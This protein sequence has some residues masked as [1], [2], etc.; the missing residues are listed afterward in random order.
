MKNDDN[1]QK[2]R[3][4][5]ATSSAEDKKVLAAHRCSPATETTEGGMNDRVDRRRKGRKDAS[6]SLLCTASVSSQGSIILCLSPESSR[7]STFLHRL[8]DYKQ[9]SLITSPV[10][11]SFFL[12]FFSPALVHSKLSPVLLHFQPLLLL[13]LLLLSVS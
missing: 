3:V 12:C 10:F 6:P 13:L 8:N 2:E 1:V 9:K 7:R 5:V 11:Y 4:S